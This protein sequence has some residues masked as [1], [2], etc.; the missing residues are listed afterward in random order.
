[1]G[2]HIFRGLSLRVDCIPRDIFWTKNTLVRGNLPV[3][4]CAPCRFA[5]ER[6]RYHGTTRKFLNTIQTMQFSQSESL[7]YTLPYEISV[8]MRPRLGISTSKKSMIHIHMVP[9]ISYGVS[10]GGHEAPYSIKRRRLGKL[11]GKLYFHCV[12]TTFYWI[13]LRRMDQTERFWS[14]PGTN[15]K[16]SED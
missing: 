2:L 10:S 5:G 11:P 8:E 16:I 3:P 13:L 7:G 1:M 14:P 4:A 15:N 9:W 12:W 6:K